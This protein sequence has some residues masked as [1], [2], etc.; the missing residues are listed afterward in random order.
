MTRQLVAG[1]QMLGDLWLT[2]W[3]H[4][5]PDVFLQGALARRKLKEA[6]GND[7]KPAKPVGSAQ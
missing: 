1:G 4:A 3:Q 6:E 5:P 7:P 2:A